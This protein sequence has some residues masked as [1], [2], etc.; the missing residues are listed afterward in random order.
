MSHEPLP[1]FVSYAS[2]DNGSDNAE[3][4]W[5]DRLI[6][7]L[8]P[9]NLDAKISI[10]TDT[11]LKVGAN[12]RSEIKT[13]IEKA[14]VAILLVSPAFLAS[15]FIRSE[16]L[17]RL[18]RKANPTNDAGLAGLETSEDMLILPIL[19]RPCLINHAE[20]EIFEGQSEVRYGRLSEFQYVPK[21][22]AMNGLSQFEQDKQYELIAQRIIEV[23]EVKDDDSLKIISPNE[24][25]L[26]QTTLIK[27]LSEFDRWWFNALRINT[28]GGKQADYKILGDYTVKQL[29]SML[30]EL[31]NHKKI[32][33]KDGKKSLVYRAKK[34]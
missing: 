8:K 32:E 12:W 17:P 21:G 5:L 9:L 7:F 27:F 30:N 14:K 19:I 18:L 3:E 11:E 13:A 29:S 25:T 24:I 1:I 20:F 34:L 15:D 26:I 23:L 2:Y 6:Q 31:S 28:W 22:S 10:W 33:R 16:E 4:R